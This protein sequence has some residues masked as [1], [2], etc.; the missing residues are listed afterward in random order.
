[1]S[2]V[3]NVGYCNLPCS[4]GCQPNYRENFL[5]W[6]S[7]DSVRIF[8]FYLGWYE[9][10][11][12]VVITVEYMHHSQCI[13]SSSSHSLNHLVIQGRSQDS[14]AKVSQRLIAME[15]CHRDLKPQAF[16]TTGV[17]Q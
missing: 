12:I 6:Y 16:T 8:S 2:T 17:L 14:F 4:F 10:V 9:K 15:I 3:A 11:N 13:K 1:M 7:C 5:I